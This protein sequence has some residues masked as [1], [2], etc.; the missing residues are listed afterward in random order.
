TR[1]TARPGASSSS[2]GWCACS[3]AGRPRGRRKIDR[4]RRPERRCLLR[5]GEEGRREVKRVRPTR[6]TTFV[7]GYEIDVDAVAN[8]MLRDDMT[9][10]VIA[11]WLSAGG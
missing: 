8:A 5:R 9:R 3:R 1:S 10:R 6:R 11:G 2:L 4:A 7:T